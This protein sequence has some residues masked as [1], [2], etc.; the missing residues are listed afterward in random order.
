MEKD[1][2]H[3]EVPN[4]HYGMLKSTRIKELVPECQV[5][6][7]TR[8]ELEYAVY[9]LLMK[10]KERAKLNGRTRIFPHDI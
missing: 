9:Q 5:G 4:R 8:D 1:N 3:R 6:K 7:A 2:L 10:A